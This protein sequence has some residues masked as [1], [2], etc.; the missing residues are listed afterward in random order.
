VTERFPKPTRSQLQAWRK[1]RLGKYRTRERLFLAEGVKVVRELERSTRPIEAVLVRDDRIEPRAALL[2]SLARRAPVYGVREEDW[3]SLSQD[4]TPEGILAVATV[5][6]KAEPAEVL[7]RESGPVLC[8]HEVNNPNNLGA[9]LR[10]A[11]WFGIRTILLDRGSV[12]ST[13]P[14]AVRTSMG[15]LFHLNILEAVDFREAIPVLR[16]RGPVAAA[17]AAGGTPPRR[18]G[19]A[20]L[21]LGSESHGLPE[22]LLALADERWT[23]PGGGDAESLSLPQ[24]AAI[25]MYAWTSG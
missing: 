16:K 3:K 21:L 23:I 13:H 5:P 11:H 25:L 8:L 10:T 2:E 24:A 20:G 1:L 18:G 7:T 6:G 15:S 12:D 4:A 19:A 14:K 17:V 22:D 9:L